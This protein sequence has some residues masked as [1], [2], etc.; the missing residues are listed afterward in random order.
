MVRSVQLAVLSLVLALASPAI[1]AERCAVLFEATEGKIEH[2]FLPSLSVATLAPEQAFALPPD[3]PAKV[4]SIQ[5]GRGSLVPGANDLKPLQAGYPI[6]IVA[7]GR[8]GVLEA[9]AGQLRFRMIE[10]EMTE[11][12]SELVQ[13]ALNQA[14]EQFHER[15]VVAP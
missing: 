12:E 7:S 11:A 14:Q 1:A 5:C 9:V 15:A 8:V 3:A 2:A 13:R 6:S 10:G 4:R